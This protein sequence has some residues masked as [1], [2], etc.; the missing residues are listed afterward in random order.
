MGLHYLKVAFSLL[1]RNR[2]YS[3]INIV[4]LAIGLACCILISLYVRVELSYENGFTNADRL[5]RISI[6]YFPVEGAR[7]RTPAQNRRLVAQ[8]LLNDFAQIENSGRIYGGNV[9]LQLDDTVIQEPAVRYVNPGIAQM[10]NFTWLQ[11]DAST[12]LDEPN[13]I[14]TGKA[15]R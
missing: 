2:L 8:A 3:A 13:S 11:G 14:V 7:L 6:E 5:Y 1:L 4:G 15:T 10:F 12:A 9:S